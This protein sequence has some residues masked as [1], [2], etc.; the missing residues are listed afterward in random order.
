MFEVIEHLENPIAALKNIRNVMERNGVFL[1]STPNRF[2]PYQ[3]LGAKIN[4]DHNYVFDKR[5]IKHLF[6]KYGFN[7]VNMKSRIFPIKLSTRNRLFIPI[8]ISKL[9]LTGRVI[10]WIAVAR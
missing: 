3:F 9:T 10:F 8:D 1:G 7:I 4:E 2:D 6:G 5:T